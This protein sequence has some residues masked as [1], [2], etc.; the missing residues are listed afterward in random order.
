MA[1]WQHSVTRLIINMLW[2][3][4][5]RQYHCCWTRMVAGTHLISWMR[6]RCCDDVSTTPR[7]SEKTCTFLVSAYCFSSPM[8]VIFFSKSLPTITFIWGERQ[9]GVNRQPRWWRKIGQ[10]SRWWLL[11]LRLLPVTA[12]FRYG[13]FPLWLLPAMAASVTADSRQRFGNLSVP[14][15]A[16][17]RYGCFPLCHYYYI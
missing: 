6:L 9:A 14:G 1:R 4:Y 7:L 10:V 3:Y 8:M 12:A 15:I 2:Y 13:C 16:A 17:S 11:P 5:H